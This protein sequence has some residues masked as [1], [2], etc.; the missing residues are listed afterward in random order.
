MQ[1]A[2]DVLLGKE[3]SSNSHSYKNIQYVGVKVPQFSFM[4]LDG[5]DPNLGV[6][7]QSTGEVACFGKNFYD[8]FLKSLIS[9]GYNIPRKNGSIL[10]SIGGIEKK[11]QLLP[12][13]KKFSELGFKI[14][15]TEH[16]ADF[17]DS[18]NID[19]IALY[20]IGEY[21]R[22]PNLEDYLIKREFDLIINI[23]MI[24]SSNNADSIIEDEYL[25]RRKAVELGIPVITTIELAEVFVD[26]IDWLNNNTLTIAETV[27]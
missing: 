11:Q 8:A 16:T 14:F 2:A 23:P 22:K 15:A 17:L 26:G 20:K 13:I 19:S 1:M 5:A 12:V 9:A 6:E 21:E 18:N 27:N 7:M 3:I 10:V 25:I 24:K 4:Q